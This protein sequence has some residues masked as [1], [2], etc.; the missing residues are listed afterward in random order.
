MRILVTATTSVLLAAHTLALTVDVQV[1]RHSY[2]GRES[3][4]AAANVFG[5]VPPYTYAW[6]NGS[7]DFQATGLVPGNYSLTVTD[8]QSD[9][10]TANF[11]VDLLNS[12]GFFGSFTSVARCAG[13]DPIVPAF[14]VMSDYDPTVSFGP[15]PFTYSSPENPWSITS[16]ECQ[17]PA[18]PIWTDL[19]VFSGTAPGNYTVNFTDGIGCP[20]TIEVTITP[21]LNDLP[22]VQ[23]VNVHPSCASSATGAI[24]FSYQGS[25]GY[26][27]LVLLR[28]DA[29]AGECAPQ[30]RTEPIGTNTPSGTRTFGS[31]LP[32]DYWLITSTDSYRWLAGTTMA[33]NA[34]KDSTLITVPSLGTDCGVL[35][36]RVYI[37]ESADCLMGSAGT[38]N[39]VPG[40]ILE[41]TPGPYYV[42]T[43]ST[44]DYGIGLSFGNYTVT[45]Q[46]VVFNQSCPGAVAL[47]SGNQTFNIG[48]A[49]GQPLDVQ[50]AMANGWARPGFELDYGIDLDNL[51]PAATGSVTLTVT[52]DPA[53]IFLSASPAPTSVV[54]NVLTW[55]SPQLVMSQVFDHKDIGVRTQVPP[56]VGL[57]GTTITTTAQLVIANNDVNL[58]NNNATSN[59]LVTGS[60]DPNDKTASTSLG[61]NAVWVIKED[62][63]IDYTIRFQNTG[64]DTAFNVIITD[65]LPATLD[66]TSIIWGAGSH[67]HSRALVGQGVLKFIFPNILLPDSNVNEP[68]SHGFVSFRIG[69]HLPVSPGTVIENI[70]NIYFDFNE[71]VITEPSVLVAE[72]STGVREDRSRE[73]SLS[74]VP[75]SDRL[76]VTASIGIASLRIIAADGREV[77]AFGVNSSS[78]EIDLDQLRAGAYLLI[79]TLIDGNEARERFIKQ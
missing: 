8:S 35:S 17:D 58:A 50:L 75:V 38:E 20:G 11:T 53:L 5:G 79:A 42:T 6:S 1:Y 52:I 61:S 9:Q 33:E 14:P 27:Y 22:Q 77:S 18:Q 57:I 63:W 45:E 23:A 34:C 37:D 76:R 4:Y 43:A 28:P 12:Y 72:F 51:T 41:I 19:L 26:E 7:T 67:A 48:C 69:P 49:G 31:L 21:E 64:T 32:G 36:G 15:A 65:T 10:A 78:T 2:C 60:I 44:G 47:A 39:R 13:D 30:V 74:P 3:G 25:L 73:L 54:G 68:M 66:P 24:T 70:A 59:Q 29:V 16:A 46:N 55:T 40:T 71:P 62:E 56:D